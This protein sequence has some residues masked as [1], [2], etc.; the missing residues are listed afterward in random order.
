MLDLGRQEAL[1]AIEHSQY[2][3]GQEVSTTPASSIGN[4][5]EIE[6]ALA[7]AFDLPV[8]R[9]RCDVPNALTDPVVKL[10]ST[11]LA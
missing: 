2:T 9:R 8:R 1:S 4:R 10:V 3:C 7:T 5:M 11:W 6:K